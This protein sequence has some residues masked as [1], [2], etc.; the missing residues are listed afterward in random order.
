MIYGLVSGLDD[1][2]TLLL[3]KS[4]GIKSDRRIYSCQSI[5]TLLEEVIQAGD[6]LLTVSV[7]RFGSVCRVVQ[8]FEL[9]KANGVAF[10]SLNE[11]YL[12]FRDG[13]ELKRVVVKHLYELA[14][15]EQISINNISSSCKTLTNNNYIYNQV[16]QLSLYSLHLTF[17]E[18]SILRRRS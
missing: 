18:S 14:N 2:N 12:N 6:T 4:K 13:K 11:P 1:D 9:L 8:V 7:N 10:K 17:G 15:A 5:G 3:L 16:R